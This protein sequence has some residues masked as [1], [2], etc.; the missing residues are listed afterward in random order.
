[1]TGKVKT[2]A[3]ESKRY[4]HGNL[5]DT[6]IIAAAQLIKE[7]ASVDFAMID[8]ARR[9]GVSSAAPYRHFKDKE[10]LLEAV[11]QLAFLALSDSVRA[12][13]QN[14]PTGTEQSI[15]AL[16]KGYIRFV[17]NHPEFYDLMWGDMGLR[18]IE[19]VD[20]DIKTSGFY[21]LVESVRQWCDAMNL[22]DYDALE[23]S[24]KLWAMGHGLACLAMNQQLDVF[25]PDADVYT[26]LESST[27][28]FLEGLKR[29]AIP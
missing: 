9:A 28:T 20:H 14:T 8:A 23:L 3:A 6:L 18:A 22:S 15:I 17:T 29:E 5:R 26:L 12:I 21:V 7:N 1:M 24:V 4:H 11:G 2:P 16:G 19:N 10:A 25:M 13:A 27:L